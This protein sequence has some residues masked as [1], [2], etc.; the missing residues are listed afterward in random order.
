MASGRL[1]FELVH[2]CSLVVVIKIRILVKYTNTH[3]SV[4][5]KLQALKN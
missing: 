4:L 2:G 5:A 1:E 3:Q